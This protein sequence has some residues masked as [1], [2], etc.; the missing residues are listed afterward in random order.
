[1]DSAFI[2]ISEPGLWFL[3]LALFV[4]L[5][6][7]CE[8]G[9]Q[10]GR[11]R[12]GKAGAAEA[13]ASD[14]TTLTGGMLALLA[15]MLGLTIDFAQHRF[16]SRRELVAVEANTIG[17]AWQ[18]AHMVGGPEGEALAGLI[19]GYARTRLEFT[20]AGHRGPIAALIAR[21]SREQA[22]IW[23]VTT[24]LARRSPTPITAILVTS[25]NEMLDASLSQRFAFDGRAPGDMLALL[26]LGSIVAIGAMGFQMGVGGAR[27]PVLTSLLLLMWTGGIV[28]TFDLN[29]PRLGNIPVDS[30]P[31]KWTIQ[32]F[33]DTRAAL[34]PPAILEEKP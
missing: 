15:F 18:R 13:H 21:T 14:T 30:S 7:A 20:R 34:T 17:T 16:E 4:V 1:M 9:Y 3:G 33:D 6:A 12:R 24:S 25:V 22:A 27:Q 2:P 5:S 19:E 28:M 32:E 8:I 23:R 26:V 11:R 10:I 31:L 29:Q